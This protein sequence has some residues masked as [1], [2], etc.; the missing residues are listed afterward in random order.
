[1]WNDRADAVQSK[2]FANAA[3][4]IPLI[5]REAKGPSPSPQSNRVE[6]RFDAL[7]LVILARS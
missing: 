5:A 7:G 4:A 1:M 6:G 3:V 2:P